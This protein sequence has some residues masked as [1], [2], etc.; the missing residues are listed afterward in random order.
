MI[1]NI[2]AI[3]P[4]FSVTVDGSPRYRG[5][6]SSTSALTRSGLRRAT[7]AAT[8]PPS[9]WPTRTAGEPT[10]RGKEGNHVG[11]VAIDV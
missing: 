1:G 6:S 7:S 4:G 9:E 8:T 11:A 3:G 10:T 2:D 5:G